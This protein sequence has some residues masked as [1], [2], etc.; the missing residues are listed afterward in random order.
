MAAFGAAFGV[1]IG[2]AFGEANDA[3]IGA[4][5]GATI[6][7]ANGAAFDVTIGVAGFLSATSV[8]PKPLFKQKISPTWRCLV[9]A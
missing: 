4:A 6:G 1:T 5:F 3:V 2:T 8:L 7:V 9:A